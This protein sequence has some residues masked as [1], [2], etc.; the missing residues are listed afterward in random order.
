MP[1]GR[2]NVTGHY[3][4]Q[5]SRDKAIFSQASMILLTGGG[6]PAPGGVCSRRGSALGEGVIGPGGGVCLL[7]AGGALCRLP[8]G[9]S[10]LRVV[11]ILLE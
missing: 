6:V 5:R 3:H 11:R 10:L 2:A 1:L 8:A 7:P 9:R 4:P